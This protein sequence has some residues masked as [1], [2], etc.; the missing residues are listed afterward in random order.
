MRRVDLP[1]DYFGE[2]LALDGNR[3]IQLTW[4]EHTAF[5]YD[6]NT[7]ATLGTYSYAGDG[8]GPCFHG[9]RFYQSDGSSSIVLRDAGT[10]KET[11]RLAVTLIS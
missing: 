11:Q 1:A 3:L 7:F 10:F 5:I 4:Q 2:G 8:W 9:R 6:A